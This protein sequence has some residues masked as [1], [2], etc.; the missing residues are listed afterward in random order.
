M[1]FSKK[2]LFTNVH[3]SPSFGQ[4]IQNQKV[5]LDMFRIEKK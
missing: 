4:K 2:F 5:T 1:F 3:Q